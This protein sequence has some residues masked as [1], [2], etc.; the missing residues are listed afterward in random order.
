MHT[1]TLTYIHFHTHGCTDSYIL[2][3]TNMGTHTPL[4]KHTKGLTPFLVSLLMLILN[5]GIA[6]VLKCVLEVDPYAAL[7]YCTGRG[8]V[9]RPFNVRPSDNLAGCDSI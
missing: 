5:M 8:M 2:S 1:H 4:Q 6:P 3:P 9:D 7:S